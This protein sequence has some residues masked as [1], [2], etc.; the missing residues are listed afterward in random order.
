MAITHVIRGDDHI[1]NT[2]K[3]VLLYRGARRAGAGVRARAADP[4]PRQEAPEQAARRHSVMRVRGAG[5]PARGDGQLPRAARLVARRRQ[6]LLLARRARSRA[7]RS[8]ASAAATPCS[9]PR[10]ST[11]STSSTSCAWTR[12][13]WLARVEPFLRDAGLWD[14]AYTGARHAWFFA[15]LELLK[16]RAK[17]LPEFVELGRFFFADVT[18]YDAAAQKKLWAAPETRDLLTALAD[19]LAPVAP[20]D[21]P[22]I[23]PVVRALADER[24]VKAT[25]L[26][27]AV[28]LAVSGSSASPGLFE[29]MALV[30]RDAVIARLRRAAA[31][32]S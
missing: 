9:T 26:M 30:G 12:A 29:M 21:P 16:P 15:V 4:R 5:L 2:P 31:H 27:Q 32:L 10:S 11:G 3:Q 20:F 8:T 7:S 23:E 19:R 13:S 17:R 14:D 28:R 18:E 6:E 25:A 24:G 1:S 22:T